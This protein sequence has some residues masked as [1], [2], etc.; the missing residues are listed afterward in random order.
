MDSK[1]KVG[2]ISAKLIEYRPATQAPE[3]RLP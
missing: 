3:A 1:I 2:R